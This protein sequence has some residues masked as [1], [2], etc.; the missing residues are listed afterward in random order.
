MIS[1]R[2][3]ATLAGI[4]F[5]SSCSLGPNYK[6]PGVDIPVTFRSQ[7]GLAQQASIA[8]LPWWDVFNDP[9]LKD[10][11]SAALVNNYDLL[12]A[13]RRIEEARAV[14]LQVRSPLF[15]QLGYEVDAQH[16]RNTALG[17]PAATGGITTSTFTGLFNAAWELDLWGRIRR[18]D[19]AARAQILANE[20]AR[21]GVM[22]IGR[23]S[24][25]ERV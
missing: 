6:R 14:R 23:A 16:A 20:E 5:L 3:P 17:N 21:R 24:C 11:V 19:E 22:Q 2:I 8:D 4:V 1:V 10:L 15:P 12:I 9:T 7:E 18:A 25:R 13:I